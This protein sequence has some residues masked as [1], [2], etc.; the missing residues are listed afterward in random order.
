MTCLRHCDL[1]EGDLLVNRDTPAPMVW[2][3]V[4]IAGPRGRWVLLDDG[5]E[6]FG[7]IDDSRVEPRFELLSREETP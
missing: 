3:L 5:T 2:L 4:E 7:P 6:H 1:R